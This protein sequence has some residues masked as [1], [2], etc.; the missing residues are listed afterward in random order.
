M[1]ASLIIESPKVRLRMYCFLVLYREISTF[2]PKEKICTFRVIFTM[3]A[4]CFPKHY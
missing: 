4:D 1:L 2:G 3:Q